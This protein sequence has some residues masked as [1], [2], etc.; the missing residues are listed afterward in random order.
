MAVVDDAGD[1]YHL[2]AAPDFD[3][4]GTAIAG[5]DLFK[6]GEKK[7]HAFY[8]E[9]RRFSFRESVPVPQLASGLDACWQRVHEWIAE[10]GHTR[11]AA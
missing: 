1:T 9:R 4:P 6:R 3:H 8:R 5:V 11:T 2:W 10:V 7:H